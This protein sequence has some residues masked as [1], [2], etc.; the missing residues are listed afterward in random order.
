MTTIAFRAENLSKLYRLGIGADAHATLRETIMAGVGRLSG[1]RKP[2]RQGPT[3][4]FWALKDVSFEVRT[5]E[6]LGILGSNGAGKST[7]LKILSRIIKPTTGHVDVRG[8]LG[9]LLEVGTGFHPDLTGREN[10]FLN[11]AVLG[12]SRTETARRLEAIIDFS[13]IE[14]FIDTPV[15]RYSSGMYLRLAFAVAAHIEPEILVIDEVLA[16][17]DASFQAKCIGKV[18]EIAGSGRTVLFV[19][20]QLHVVHRL[21]T[22]AILMQ[23]GRL[24]A[25]GSPS[26]VVETYLRGIE[27]SATQ[28][29]ATRT[30]RMGE[31]EVRLIAVT[32]EA[33]GGTPR[34]GSP[35]TV[36]FTPSGEPIK[37]DCAFTIVDELGFPVATFDTTETAASDRTDGKDFV[38][39]IGSLTLRPGRYRI[40]ATLATHAGVQEDHIEGAT[41]FVV[42]PG[43]HDGRS[44]GAKLGDGGALLPHRWTRPA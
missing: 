7:L 31:G 21:C 12:M 29:L 10:I 23:K 32:V 19:S 20:H 4:D 34:T 18:E 36:R 2:V 16:V 3:N 26:A 17:G 15:K 42:Q 5:G 39:T 41:L 22:R 44:P 35:L 8:R 13:G 24:V 28:D 40:D 11:G 6:V 33:E 30:D 25:D 1:R 14:P 37:V 43:E 27:V 38:C 9:A